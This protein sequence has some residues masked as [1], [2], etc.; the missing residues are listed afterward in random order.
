[1]KYFLHNH[2]NSIAGLA[3]QGAVL[4]VLVFAV[5]WGV[6]YGIS[7][8]S[9]ATAGST[10]S[11]PGPVTA[12]AVSPV[13]SP[14]PQ[15]VPA[16]WLGLSGSLRA[17]VGTPDALRSDATFALLA[18]DAEIADPGVHQTGLST[19]SG[20]SF[21]VVAMHP[22]DPQR[23]AMIGSYRVG[24]WPAPTENSMYARP[25]G[26]IEVTQDNESTPVSQHFQLRDFLTHDQGGVWPKALVI[27]PK[28]IDK[29]ELISQE[30]ERRGLPNKLHVMSG[31]R[32]PQYNALE[33]HPGGRARLSRHMYG[34]ASDVFVDADGNGQMDD[35]NGDGKV[36]IAD[37]RILF[38]AAE[39]VEASHPE[40]VG[41]LSAYPATVAHGPF[42]H[43][44]TRGK[45][46][47]W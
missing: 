37:A 44:D 31:F 18:S 35:L 20:D 24:S 6:T 10:A 21:Y 36:T 22:Y 13:A 25:A 45:R 16:A 28:L 32:T 38:Q 40:L 27:R 47:R 34:D 15:P 33:V 30:L 12:E 11:G 1:M 14:E 23:G 26:V 43:V 29:L 42:V 17:M 7:M 9:P 3:F 2:R 39:S 5:A 46:A 19:P 8:A 41:G 4:F